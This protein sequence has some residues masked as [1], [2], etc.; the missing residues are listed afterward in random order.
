MNLEWVTT[1]KFVELSK[2]APTALVAA[3]G[4]EPRSTA[5]IPRASSLTSI[6]ERVALTFEDADDSNSL[7]HQASFSDSGFRLSPANPDSGDVIAAE[8]DSLLS[9]DHIRILL[10]ISS[11]TRVWYGRVVTFL[12]DRQSKSKEEV[13]VYFLYFPGRYPRNLIQDVP[14]EIFQPLRGFGSFGP[15]QLPICLL[16]GLGLDSARA[17]SLIHRLEP[18][19]AITFTSSLT[20]DEVEALQDQFRFPV[21]SVTSFHYKIHDPGSLFVQVESLALGVENNFR[22]IG[23]SLGPKLFGLTLML[24]AVVRPRLSIW[25]VSSGRHQKPVAIKARTTDPFV[26]TTHWISLDDS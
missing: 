19:R 11:M 17:D 15:P 14:N 20:L 22:I 18:E 1:Q 8:L 25:R 9:K 4:W 6:Q 5:I 7:Q 24:V 23:C 21:G 13:R 26:C 10:D 2:E 12:R 3:A 16:L